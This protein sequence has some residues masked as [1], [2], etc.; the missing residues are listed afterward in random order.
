MR[1]VALAIVTL[2]F[3]RP[4]WAQ[5]AT[6]SLS[7]LYL[8][9]CHTGLVAAQKGLPDVPHKEELLGR[10]DEVCRSS[11]Q[12]ASR[13]PRLQSDVGLLACSAATQAMFAI[14][15]LRGEIDQPSERLKW[16][17]SDCLADLWGQNLLSPDTQTRFA[18]WMMRRF[19]RFLLIAE[20]AFFA[21]SVR[22]TEHLTDLELTV[23][24]SVRAS[25]RI[26]GDG[27]RADAVHSTGLT[28][29]IIVGTRVGAPGQKEG[30][31]WCDQ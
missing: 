25:V 21:D 6:D 18:P 24:L 10:G 15:G 11:L 20:E 19:L 23:P 28:C 1:F 16:S 27:Y 9:A 29:H 31:P 4:A 14:Y 3:I 17:Q 2:V 30:E 26:I 8:S 22:Y 13:D 7:K 12:A 5:G